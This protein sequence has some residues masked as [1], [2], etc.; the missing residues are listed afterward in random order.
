MQHNNCSIVLH[1]V[2][3]KK[4]VRDNH[5]L[6]NFTVYSAEENSLKNRIDVAADTDVTLIEILTIKSFLIFKK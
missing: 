2:S 6:L 3:K 4:K 1:P 5:L